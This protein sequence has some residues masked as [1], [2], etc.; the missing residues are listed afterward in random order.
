MGLFS[1]SGNVQT[2]ICAITVQHS[3]FP[4]SQACIIIGPESHRPAARNKNLQGV[5]WHKTRSRGAQRLLRV[6]RT[7][8]QKPF[9][10]RSQN[11]RH[12]MERSE[13]L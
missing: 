1:Q 4:T 12:Q 9:I 13:I 5:E 11:H 6:P 10:N 2:C 7:E 8:I 3:L